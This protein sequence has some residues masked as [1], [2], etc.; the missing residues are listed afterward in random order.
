MSNIVKK[1]GTILFFITLIVG[2][3][4]ADEVDELQKQINDLQR[5]LELSQNAT[6]TNEQEYNKLVKQLQSVKVNVNTVEKQIQEQSVRIKQEEEDIEKTKEAISALSK[7]YYIQSRQ[8]EAMVLESL[9]SP[10]LS[11]GLKQVAYQ[12]GAF[13]QQKDLLIQSAYTLSTLSKRKAELEEKKKRL[14]V[15]REAVD[16]QSQFLQGEITKAKTYEQQLQGKI[17]E[18]TARQQAILA[19]RSGT[20]ITSV[21]SV[22]IGADFNA[23]I[24]FKSQAPRNSFAVFAFGAYTHRKGMSQYG[25]KGRA[26]K[27]QNYKDIL[28]AYYGKEPVK[29]DTGGQIKVSGIGDIEFETRYLYGIAEMPS[30][31]P[32]EALKAQAVA[33][34]TYA[35]RY[36]T[37]GKAIC[38]N[39]ACQVFSSSKADNPPSEWRAAVDETRGEVLEDVITYYSS[40]TGGY[41]T[42]SG[43]D[44]EDKQ[45]GGEWTN[46]AYESMAGSPW[47]Y[48]AWYRKGYSPSGESCGRNHP[49][50][51]QE[52]FSD[53]INA[54]IVRTNPQGADVSRI[55]P[56]TINQC[57]VGGSGGSPYSLSELR[58]LAGKS[59]GAVTNVTSVRVEHTNNGQTATVVL[60]TNRGTLRIPGSEFKTTFNIRAPGY[61]SIPQS[62]FAFFN[63]EK[64]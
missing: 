61:I 49:W 30:S 29:K 13:E 4:V 3:V 51:S 2:S 18:L 40:T 23:S 12:E 62:G 46:R 57:A 32:K 14:L 53:I 7:S 10:R 11:E 59:G 42:T 37:E 55:V 41:I 47:F 9:F 52:E 60:E 6:K 8:Q 45:G 39:E 15:V 56:V 21:G 16:K 22:P 20:S 34:R 24:A 17:A 31:F 36:K 48:K 64:T 27:G 35:Y 58:E 1:I 28:K 19:A 44:T 43:W 50:L 63:I 54:W 33:A 25:A 5:S 26:E 38:T